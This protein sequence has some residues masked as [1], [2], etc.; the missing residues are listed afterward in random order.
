MLSYSEI[1]PKKVILVDGTPHEVL[2]SWVF[3][4]Q[5]RKPVNQTK[6][7]NL[8]TGGTIEYTFHQP[9][10]AEEADLS[11]RTIKFIYTRNGEYWFM[12]PN[13]PKDRFPLSETIV[14]TQ[15]QYLK[16]DMTVEAL[17]FDENIIQI[18]IPIKVELKVTEAP[19]NIRGN[20]AQGGNKVATLETGATVQVPLFVE[21]GDVIRINTDTGEYVERV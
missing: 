7:R 6:L 14:G 13:N 2:S 12:D 3:R 21:I 10:K 19:P 20:T 11:K 4:K 15:G 17:V 5:M 16:Q 1:L 8:L 18:K 9:D